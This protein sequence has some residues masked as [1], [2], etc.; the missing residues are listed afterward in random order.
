MNLTCSDHPGCPLC[1]I[2]H[3]STGQLLPCGFPGRDVP[4]AALL[5]DSHHLVFPTVFQ[6]LIPLFFFFCLPP[7]CPPFL[8]ELNVSY[9]SL[10][11]LTSFW[12]EVLA[13]YG[14]LLVTLAF[15]CIPYVVALVMWKITD[16]W[17]EIGILAIL[18]WVIQGTLVTLG[19]C[20]MHLGLEWGG[21][22]LCQV[23]VDHICNSPAAIWWSFPSV[24]LLSL[25]NLDSLSAIWRFKIH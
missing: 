11:E 2:Y 7:L 3:K 9:G 17:G 10:W 18:Q 5:C 15:L 20:L 14:Q 16:N 4:A 12:L 8:H 1:Y 22:R 25:L 23:Q 13:K 19:F 6:T 21:L 24:S